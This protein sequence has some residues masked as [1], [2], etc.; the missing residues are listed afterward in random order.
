MKK[1]YYDDE[2]CGNLNSWFEI[3]EWCLI[4]RSGLRNIFCVKYDKGNL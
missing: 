1:Y 2:G 3:V 4:K